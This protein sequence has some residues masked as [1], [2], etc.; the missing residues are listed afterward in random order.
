MSQGR[1]LVF[2]TTAVWKK[3]TEYNVSLPPSL[4]ALFGATLS[5][6]ELSFSTDTNSV[7]DTLVLSTGPD[8]ALVSGPFAVAFHFKIDGIEEQVLKA[9]RSV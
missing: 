4:P 3:A 2:S 6:T 9:I 5:E 1:N 8:G 7:R